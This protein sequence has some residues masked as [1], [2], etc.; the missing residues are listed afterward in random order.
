MKKQWSVNERFEEGPYTY[1][2]IGF[3]SNGY[4]IS[5]KLGETDTLE[6]E[7]VG[8]KSEAKTEEAKVVSKPV[9]QTKPANKNKQKKK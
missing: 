1:K 9:V 7:K 8:I 4:R 2:V 5:E 3:D 6:E